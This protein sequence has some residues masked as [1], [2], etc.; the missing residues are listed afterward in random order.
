[1]RTKQVRPERQKF[2]FEL[3]I[4]RKTDK[5]AKKDYI[6]FDFR[7][8]KVFENFI[9]SMNVFENVDLEKKEINFKIEGLSAPLSTLPQSGYAAYQYKLFDFKNTEYLV[10]LIKQGK[11]KTS[12][13]LKI[14]KNGV[15]ITKYPVKNFIKL[16]TDN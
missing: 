10:K 5:T 14:T 2:E 12:I 11:D 3:H 4:S 15:K 13:K 9:Y 6:L 16:I 7:T 1:M 8:T